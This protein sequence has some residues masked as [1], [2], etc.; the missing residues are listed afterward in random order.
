MALDMF[1]PG[2][3]CCM[4]DWEVSEIHGGEEKLKALCDR[5]NA[6]GIGIMSWLGISLG[7]YS[8]IGVHQKRELGRTTGFGS[9]KVFAMKESG[10][11]PDTG[12]PMDLCSIDLNTPMYDYLIENIKGVCERTGITGWLMDSYSNL[13]WWQVDYAGGTMKPQFE[14]MAGIYSELTNAGQYCMPEALVAFSNHSSLHQFTGDMYDG[15]L[16]GYS[17]ST[18]MSLPLLDA[19]NLNGAKTETLMLT[20]DLPIDLMFRCLSHR[21]A[22]I[23]S[24]H[25]VARDQWDEE[26]TEELKRVFRTYKALRDRMVHRTVLHEDQGVIYTGGEGDQGIYFAYQNIDLPFELTDADTGEKTSTVVPNRVY[27]APK[28]DLLSIVGPGSQV[29][30]A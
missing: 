13:S 15:D 5:A 20:G 24:F 25:H 10:S 23:S 3:M 22:P 6:K 14:K 29:A 16:L 2:S 4:I 18:N 9:N 11:H 28:D 1:R 8:D 30:T 7:T 19:S 12:Y 21:R 17:Y 26:S 27:E